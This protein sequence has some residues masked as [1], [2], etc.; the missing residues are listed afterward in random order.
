[1]GTIVIEE[2]VDIGLPD[3]QSLAAPLYKN[4]VAVTNDA[5]TSSSDETVVLDSRTRYISVYGVEAHRVSV[6]SA[7][8]GTKYAY[9]GAGE[10]RDISVPASPGATI[11]YRTNA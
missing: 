6:T 4:Q 11:S 1:M 2:W 5:T 7:T 3:A 10:R 9:I 8:T